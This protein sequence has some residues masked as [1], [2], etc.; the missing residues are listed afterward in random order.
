MSKSLPSVVEK[1]LRYVKIDTQSVHNVPTVPSTEK[2]KDLGR[3]LMEELEAL[4]AQ[5]IRMDDHGCVYATIP[6]NCETDAPVVG[7]LAHMDTTPDV[8]GTN[9]NPRIV[10]NYDGGD[11]V[12]NEELGIVMR[13]QVFDNMLNYVGQDFIVTDGTTLLGADDK[14]GVAE[15]MYMAEYLLTHPEVKHGTI[16]VGFTTDEEVG[17]PGAKVFDIEYFGADFA[18]T[19]DGHS[20]GEYNCESF[21]A[22][23]AFI[24]VHGRQ[25]HPGRAKNKMINAIIVA[26]EF[27]N[28]I[29][30]FDTCEH[31][32]R[33]EG[34]FPI[35]NFDGT[36]PLTKMKYLVRDFDMDGF[37]NRK[38]FLRRI[39]D[40]L[41]G[42]YGEGTVEVEFKDTYFSMY[43]AI[44]SNPAITEHALKA[45]TDAGVTPRV[46]A[47]R[48]G[49]DGSVLSGRGLPCPNISAG[50][51]SGHSIYEYITV[52]ALET[53]ANAIIN[54]AVSFVE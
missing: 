47:V 36:V 46:E 22:A 40:Y 21:N 10:E 31:V 33:R 25:V 3:L 44:K 4:G 30:S 15:I 11:I 45:I 35:T 42:V 12:L 41:N 43:E 7:F 5:D 13:T 32:D 52:Q 20:V 50:Y 48:G 39:G 24:T 27:D 9:V 6:A 53:T 38:E 51:Q 14:A 23:D 8:S 18:Y 49:T 28:L 16:K 17:C 26:K 54:L 37:N 34:Y 2:Q 19:L 1:F 29:P